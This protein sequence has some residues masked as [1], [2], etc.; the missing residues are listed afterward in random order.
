MNNTLK[1]IGIISLIASSIGITGCGSDDSSSSAVPANAITFSTSNA[2][3]AVGNVLAATASILA[4]GSTTTPSVT[5]IINNAID[6]IKQSRNNT[7]QD[8]V[9]GIAFNDTTQCWNSGSL[10]ESGNA[11]LN[12][13][14]GNGSGTTVFNNCDE[15][16]G[17]TINGTLNIG[18]SW[19]DSTGD[20]TDTASGSITVTY[21][22]TSTVV[23]VK[24]LSFKETGNDFTGAYTISKMNYSYDPG[25]NGF[26]VGITTAL[27]GINDDCPT[28]AVLLKGAD[29]TQVQAT[30]NGA[31]ANT[32]TV[33]VDTG[34]GFTAAIGSPIS[35]S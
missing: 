30:F 32:I 3:T 17:V 27:N 11:T 7:G 13:N 26:S 8:P 6:T 29:K 4:K 31:T 35:C 5:E 23:N 10:V 34:S 16:F 28:G 18:G 12:D 33:E 20:Y 14:G 25:S 19:N 24:N 15:G 1:Q 22:S 21:N 2:A 9:S